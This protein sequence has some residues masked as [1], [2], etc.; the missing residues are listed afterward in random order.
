MNLHELPSRDAKGYVHV[1]IE[2]PAGAKVKL[3]YEPEFGAFSLARPLPLG[4]H[5][6]FDWGFVPSTLAE[7]GDPVDAMVLLDTPTAAGVVVACQAIGVLKVEQVGEDGHGRERN[8]RV[9]LTPVR[10][11]RFE[12]T[13]IHDLPRR[14]RDE[15]AAFFQTAVLFGHKDLEILGWAGPAEGERLIRRGEKAWQKQRQP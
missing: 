11:A 10:D 5:Y 3:K 1:V 2:T 15:L 4:V 8:D 14:V 6:P 12:A 9:L 13:D 7:D